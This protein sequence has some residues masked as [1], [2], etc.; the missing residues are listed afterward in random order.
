MFNNKL[1]L[2]QG[3]ES[4]FTS[5]IHLRIFLEDPWN[6]ELFWIRTLNYELVLNRSVLVCC[7]LQRYLSWLHWHLKNNIVRLIIIITL[8]ASNLT[9]A[10]G[11]VLRILSS[12]DLLRVNNSGVL[13]S[14]LVTILLNLNW[15]IKVL[16]GHVSSPDIVFRFDKASNLVIWWYL[17]AIRTVAWLL[18][19]VV[20]NPNAF[21]CPNKTSW[22]E[23]LVSV[24]LVRV[25]S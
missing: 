4:H 13:K 24:S 5:H 11:S 18:F 1:R 20:E 15:R 22:Y 8:I 9:I 16:K 10:S 25:V 21:V 6:G 23:L 19:C 14:W 2:L 3:F 17:I 7:D 12:G